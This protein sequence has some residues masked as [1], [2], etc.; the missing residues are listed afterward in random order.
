VAFTRHG[1]LI[2]GTVQGDERAH[3]IAR[4]GG[5]RMCVQCKSDVTAYYFGVDAPIEQGT[6]KESHTSPDRDEEKDFLFKAKL[7]VY[8]YF[9][10]QVEIGNTATKIGITVNDV[11]VVWFSKTLQNWKAC[12]ATTVPDGMYYEL[13]F[14]GDKRE[15]YLDAYKKI[16][17]IVMRSPQD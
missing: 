2:P 7:A 9:N 3:V 1:H 16:D 6:F 10:H 4:C 8:R 5:P 17:N 11:F 13:T 14:N 15:L 12:L